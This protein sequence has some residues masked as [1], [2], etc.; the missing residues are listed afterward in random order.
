VA[1]RVS[2]STPGASAS[3]SLDFAVAVYPAFQ[4]AVRIAD[5]TTAQSDSLRPLIEIDGAGQ[6]F[7]VWRDREELRFTRSADA[8]ARWSQPATIHRSVET[9]YR[10]S[11]AFDRSATTVLVAWEEDS[12]IRAMR[13]SDAGQS[14]TP[15]AVLTDAST[16][17]ASNPGMFVDPSGTIFLACL[18]TA[19]RG[20]P[21]YSA[22][23]LRS[24][25]HGASF[26]EIG[27]IPWSTF[28]TGDSSPQL[29]A[30]RNGTL[31]LVFTSD[32]GTRYSTSYSSFSTDGGRNW[33]TPNRVSVV[34]PAMAVDDQN[35]I[36][37]VGAYMYLPYM[38]RIAFMRSTDQ[39]GS[40]FS[41]EFDGTSYAASDIVINAYQSVDVAWAHQFARSFNRGSTWGPVVA[42][43]DETAAANPSFVEDASGRIYLVWWDMNGGIYFKA[44]TPAAP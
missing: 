26:D 25:N 12:T 6:L 42:Y 11:M 10:F 13:S 44:S 22:M 35:A 30:D 16:T 7:V 17:S 19:P 39:G 24:T 40:W 14:W 36:D 1:V 3:N 41:H 18:G 5:A 4:A 33:S 20:G 23:V 37:V 29:A 32:F 27:R 8:G 31:Y 15:P 9:S 43:D 2:V 38:Y 34:A 21:P 28:F